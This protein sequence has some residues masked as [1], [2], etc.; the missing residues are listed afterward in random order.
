MISFCNSPIVVRNSL[1]RELIDFLVHSLPNAC[2][3]FSTLVAYENKV[4]FVTKLVHA[5]TR[6]PI[7][8]TE[9]LSYIFTWEAATERLIVNSAITMK[10]ARVR[11]KARK[12]HEDDRIAKM[13]NKLGIRG[14]AWG[15]LF[16]NPPSP[17]RK[18]PSTSEKESASGDSENEDKEA[19]NSS[20]NTEEKE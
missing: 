16:G 17:E 2:F 19:E 14:H 6:D 13:Y 10:E 7:P 5:L 8:L 18:S 11:A 9:E 3:F 4:E 20:N 1:W 12:G 15:S